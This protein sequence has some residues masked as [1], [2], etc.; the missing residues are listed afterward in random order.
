MSELGGAD[1]FGALAEEQSESHNPYQLV[2]GS[3]VGVIGGGPAGS[4]TTYFLIEMAERVGIDLVVD[5]F[6]LKDFTEIGPKGCNHC[7]G[8]VSESL[9]QFMAADGLNI[10]A[11]VIQRGIDSYVLHMDVGTVPI[12]TPLQEKRIAAVYRGSGPRGMTEDMR[13]ADSFDQYV[14]GRALEKGATLLRE[15]VDKVEIV[16]GMPQIS[17][18]QG[19]TREYD[20]VVGAVGANSPAQKIFTP[21]GFGYEAPTTTK[22]YITELPLGREDVQKYL[23]TSM[24]VFLLNIPRVE[25]A[26]FVPK[27]D[28]ATMVLLGENIDKAL[29]K[30]F[31][32]APEVVECLPPL[33]QVPDAVCHCSPMI[34]VREATRPFTDR[35]VLTGDCGVA[36]L[37]K[38][39]IGSAYRCAKAI[40]TTAVMEGVSA[41][42]FTAHYLPTYKAIASDNS[43]GK[44]VFWVTRQ[45]QRTRFVRRGLLSM[46]VGEQYGENVLPRMST[47]LW[48]T[49]TGSAHY[50][51][52]FLR[53]LRPTFISRLVWSIVTSLIGLMPTRPNGESGG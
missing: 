1:I 22:T 25:F 26:A 23:G 9:V 51:D 15:R 43:V 53:T 20:F 10:P 28:F 6:D 46:V 11:E 34:N 30:T 45:I 14:L 16:D 2:D 35:I 39:G 29:I 50:K 24:H 36:R 40:A 27:G 44:F 4:F 31:L 33:F 7:G 47:V 17:T 42:D 32:S 49:F 19:T 3:R 8:I 38:D 18:R 5:I 48:D 37:Y 41:E 21:A 13:F 52:V 12:Q